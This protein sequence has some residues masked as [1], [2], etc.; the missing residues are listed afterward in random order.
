MHQAWHICHFC[1]WNHLGFGV[2]LCD[3]EKVFKLFVFLTLVRD[4]A[5]VTTSL[6]S[7][8]RL[9]GLL[10]RFKGSTGLWGCKGFPGGSVGR[11]SACSVW[12]LGGEDPLENEMATYSSILAWEIPWTEEPGWLQSMGT[13]ESDMTERLTTTKENVTGTHTYSWSLALFFSLD[14]GNRRQVVRQKA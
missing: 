10:W 1:I 12:S 13:Q 2:L 11:E 8:N 6:P 3:L 4:R 5:I 9:R 7:S 14:P